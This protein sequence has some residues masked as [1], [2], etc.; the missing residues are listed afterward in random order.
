MEIDNVII[1]KLVGTAISSVTW[2]GG[3]DTE[4]SGGF[5]TD[6]FVLDYNGD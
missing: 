6:I 5:K 3:E 4:T 1:S 2:F